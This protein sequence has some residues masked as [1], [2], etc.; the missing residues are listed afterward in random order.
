MS[1]GLQHLNLGREPA[2]D[3]HDMSR[4]GAT[5]MD[6]AVH[7]DAGSVSQAPGLTQGAPP[8][9]SSSP[10]CKGPG[11]GLDATGLGACARELDMPSIP[12][13]TVDPWGGTSYFAGGSALPAGR[14]RIAYLDGCLR[15]GRGAEDGW[16]VHALNP[17][18][19]MD[20]VGTTLAIPPGTGGISL[21]DGAFATLSECVAANRELCPVDFAFIGGKLLVSGYDWTH[22]SGVDVVEGES[23]GGV[24]PTFRL[25]R[26]E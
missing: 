12:P 6:A 26:C 23:E 22:V 13:L 16:S 9:A 14:Y 17:F 8:T 7:V 19:V 5:D 3:V 4:A 18:W 2:V 10:G 20:E 11:V 21:Q 1:C 25:T 24:S 15:W